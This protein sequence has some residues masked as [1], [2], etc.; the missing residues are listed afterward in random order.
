MKKIII[1]LALIVAMG[2]ALT[3][4][5]TEVS[6]EPKEPVT[7]AF[8][9]GVTAL[10][11][12]KMISEVPDLG[13][14]VDYDILVSPDL[15]SAKILREEADVAIIPTNLAVQAHNKGIDYVIMGTSTWGNLYI[16]GT[17]EVDNVADLQGKAINTFGRGL[18]PEL[19]LLMVLEG[20][21]LDPETD[22][23]IN[24]MGSAAEIAPLLV[25]ERAS[26]GV[27]PEPA[28]S[29][30][31]MKNDDVKVL[32]D[33]NGLWAE[34]K[35]VQI[36]YPQSCLVVKRELVEN[37]PEFIERFLL[38][39]NN[40]IQ[41][42]SENPE[43][44]GDISEEFSLGPEKAAVINGISRMNIGNFPIE[45]SLEEYH[46]YYQ[47]IMDFAPDFIGGELPDEDIYYKR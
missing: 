47:A 38:E 35:G 45:N 11:A 31:L 30:V 6:N 9:E 4:C 41:W 13:R 14:D 12:G 37:D 22:L 40:S 23:D 24:Y 27:I 36:G 19:V 17:E 2:A 42:A 25:S 46:V 15:L 5:S 7:F 18:T 26:L 44:L 20:N 1:L 43:D 3:G 21:G 29:G 16:A 32:F 8:M 10:T 39:Y 34:A 33:L 28:L